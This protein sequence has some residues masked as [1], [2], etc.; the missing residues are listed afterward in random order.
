MSDVE[1]TNA[2]P[3]ESDIL[4]ELSFS[5]LADNP[6]VPLWCKKLE[7]LLEKVTLSH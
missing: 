1:Y 4:D 2:N 6:S 3:D 7:S 5:N